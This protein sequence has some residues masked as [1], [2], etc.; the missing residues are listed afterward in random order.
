MNLTD[1][2]TVDGLKRTRDGYLTGSVRASRTGIQTYSG[3]EVGKP[4][5]ATVRV[6][7]PESEVFKKD[8]MA[9]FTTIPV[10]VDH[11]AIAVTADNWRQFAVGSTGEDIARDGDFIR[12]PIIVKDAAAIRQIENGKRQLS[13]GYT[14]DLKWET[15][16]T[17]GGFTYDAIQTNLVGNHLAIVDQARGGPDLIIDGDTKHMKT[18]LIDGH[19][20]EV[21]DAA[22]IAVKNLLDKFLAADTA[23]KTAETAVGTL[24]AQVSTKDGEI[25]ALT[26]QVAD[27][28]MTPAQLD[29]AVAARVKV[30]DAAKRVFPAVVTDGKTE[31]EIKKSAVVSK[32]GDA[33]A[34]MNDQAI[35]GAFAVYATVRPLSAMATRPRKRLSTT[36]F[37]T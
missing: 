12:V 5:M 33:A 16:T 7:R 17:D 9:S 2:L 22:E 10:T 11:P 32:L 4:E 36:A 19:S 31:A 20:V 27:G 28:K 25:A 18:V 15:G 6:Y 3:A 8:A 21:S 13:M 1:A 37:T 24:T 30:I 23:R 34:T 29:A 35:D 14:C 26:K